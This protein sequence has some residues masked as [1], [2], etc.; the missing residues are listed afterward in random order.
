[1]FVKFLV[2]QSSTL[3]SKSERKDATL[4]MTR[5]TTNLCMW[6]RSEIKYLKRSGD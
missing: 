3:A 6:K 5:N 1:M 2:I 4:Y